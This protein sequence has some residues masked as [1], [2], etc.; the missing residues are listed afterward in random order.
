MIIA[1]VGPELPEL[2]HAHGVVLPGGKMEPVG[3]P[4]GWEAM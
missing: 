3:K 4:S 2:V 1:K